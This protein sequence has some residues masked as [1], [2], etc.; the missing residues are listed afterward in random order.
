MPIRCYDKRMEMKLKRVLVGF[1]VFSKV[2]ADSKSLKEQCSLGSPEK[3]MQFSKEFFE[4]YSVDPQAGILRNMDSITRVNV[5]VRC[6]CFGGKSRMCQVYCGLLR[7]LKVASGKAP[8][9]NISLAKWQ[10]DGE[11]Y[12]NPIWNYSVF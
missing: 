11:E 2:S 9:Y 4:G 10:N 5:L 12:E 6:S 3:L 7:R 8:E 1:K